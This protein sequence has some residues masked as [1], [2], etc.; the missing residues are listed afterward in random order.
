MLT[1]K[2]YIIMEIYFLDSLDL[3]LINFYELLHE[4]LDNNLFF[5]VDAFE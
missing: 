4:F 1:E 5:D 3:Y 2:S